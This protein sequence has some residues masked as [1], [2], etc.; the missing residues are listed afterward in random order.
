MI[1]D[2][3]SEVR[4]QPPYDPRM[5]AALLFHSC[6]R[7]IQSSR[8]IAQHYHERMDFMPVMACQHADFRTAAAFRTC[9]LSTLGG[10]LDQILNLCSEMGLASL[11]HVPPAGRE[12]ES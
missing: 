4:G 12:I 2:S 5:M 3:Y 1:V 8:E 11:G 6:C 9:Y 7:G 10:L